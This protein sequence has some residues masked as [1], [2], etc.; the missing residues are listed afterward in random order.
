MERI[1][2]PELMDD[3]AQALAY[4]Q[5]DFVE[6]NRGFVDRFRTAFPD[7][8]RSRVV[9]LGCGPAD[10]PIRLVRLMPTLGVT[11]VDASARGRGPPRPPRP[12]HPPARGGSPPAGGARRPA[13]QRPR[14]PAGVVTAR[15]WVVSGRLPCPRRRNH[16][17][18]HALT[19]RSRRSSS[20]RGT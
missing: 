19:S 20:A 4:A 7:L 13:P 11:A 16:D 2:E 8:T 15:P 9:D 1:L 3:E 18:R 17:R 14:P 5:A 12:L 6:V 10:I